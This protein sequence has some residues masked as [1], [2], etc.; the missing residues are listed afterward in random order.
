MKPKELARRR[1]LLGVALRED[2]SRLGVELD[3]AGWLDVNTL[4]IMLAHHGRPMSRAELE[5]VVR[6]PSESAPAF[7]FS[8]DGSKIR[9]A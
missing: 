5:Q 1:S 8:D 3:A 4:I 2:P 9:A 7:A 6:S